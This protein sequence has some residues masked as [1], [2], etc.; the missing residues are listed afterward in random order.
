[1]AFEGKRQLPRC[2]RLPSL[3]REVPAF[4]RGHLEYQYHYYTP[5]KV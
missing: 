1:M 2:L 5:F 3:P 4:Y